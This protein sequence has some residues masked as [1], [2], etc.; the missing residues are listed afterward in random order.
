MVPSKAEICVFCENKFQLPVI[1]GFY[2]VGF[3]QKASIYV[4][5]CSS[6]THV[7]ASQ[8]TMIIIEVNEPRYQNIK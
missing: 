2:E 3:H 6:R 4:I 7:S 1:F 5:T 8:I